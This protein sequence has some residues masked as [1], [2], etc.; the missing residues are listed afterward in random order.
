MDKTLNFRP[1]FLIDVRNFLQGKLSCQ[2]N[3]AAALLQHEL[4]AVCPGNRHL[5]AGMNGKIRKMVS[6]IPK[7]PQILYNHPIQSRFIKRVQIF[8][9]FLNLMIL[10]QRI[11]SKV[12]AFAPKMKVIYS[13]QQFFFCK[14]IRIGPC[15]EFTACSVHSVCTC[16]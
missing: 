15:A 4:C 10:Q 2:N 11:Y 5:S 14:I 9:Q 13:L 8:L 7:R 1:G 3:P 12:E 16:I 6:D